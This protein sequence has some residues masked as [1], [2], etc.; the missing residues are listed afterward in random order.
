MHMHLSNKCYSFPKEAGSFLSIHILGAL[1][2]RASV[3]KPISE[4][5]H[6]T[7]TASQHYET[8]YFNLQHR[9]PPS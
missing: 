3:N 6:N 7:G 1:D 8:P 9:H 4:Q 5:F 2:L